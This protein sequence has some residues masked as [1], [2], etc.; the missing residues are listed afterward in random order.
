MAA[1]RKQPRKAKSKQPARRAAKKATRKTTRKAARKAAPAAAVPEV[2][3]VRAPARAGRAARGADY[4][5]AA[6]PLAAAALAGPAEYDRARPAKTRYPIPAADFAALKGEAPAAKLRGKVAA[7]LA[8]DRGKKGAPRPVA[9]RLAAAAVAAPLAPEAAAPST[10]GSFS[11]LPDTTWFPYD[12]AVAAGPQHVL[13]A[14]NSSVAVYRKT[15][16]GAVLQRTLTAWFSNVISQAKIFDPKA[17]YDQHAGRWVLAAVALGTNTNTSFFLLSVSKTS[18]PLG[19]WSNYKLDASVD[20]TTQTQN[21][22]DYPGLGVDA[23]AL[24]LTAN[25]FR[26][27]GGFQYGKIRIIPK[28]G[29]YSGGAATFRDIVNLKNAESSAAFT[30]QPC[31]TYGAPQVQ[32]FVNSLFPSTSAPTRTL[33]SL[34][35]L[36]DPLGTPT[37]VRRNVGVNPY[38]LPPDAAQK[39]SSTPL[40]TGD[41]R[42]LNAVFRGGSVWLALCSRHD[43][44]TGTN[45]AV[46][47]WFQ[48][49]ATSGV[50]VQQG[51]YGAPGRHY[52]FPAVMPDGNGNLVIVFSRSG[53]SEFAGLRTTGRLAADPL[54]RLQNSAEFKAG[55]ARYVK[56][57][58]MGRNRWG[59]YSGIANDP[60]DDRTIWCYGGFAAGVNTWGSWIGAARF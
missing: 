25:M 34:W 8:R 48:I 27:G 33:L 16:G 29:P 52:C 44:G 20:G 51:L 40:D 37:I 38:G 32:Y 28:D 53:A 50:I 22:A 31:H 13:A 56:L 6:R 59:D 10:L 42:V 49:D 14:V 26:F 45:V 30:I 9:A 41:V 15:G 54:G 35:S 11:G 12:C 39:G 4:E 21:W 17:L 43:W 47:H 5:P 57:D 24:Y 18:D 60:T 23:Q 19:G 58:G 55:A 1:T 2:Q 7:V 46:I 3:K 36:T